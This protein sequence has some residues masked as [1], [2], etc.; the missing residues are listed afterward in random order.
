MFQAVLFSFVHGCFEGSDPDPCCA[1]VR[2]FIYFKYRVEFV[3]LLCDL[4]YLVGRDCIYAASKGVELNDLHI[5]SRSNEFCCSVQ[6]RMIDPLVQRTD[7]SRKIRQMKYGVFCENDHIEGCDDLVESVVD[8]RIEMVRTSCENDALF[9]VLLGP[10]QIHLTVSFDVSL[11]LSVFCPC[12]LHCLS[13][14]L[15]GHAVF[16]EEAVEFSHHELIVVVRQERMIELRSVLLEDLVHVSCDHFRIRGNDRTVV[17][18]WLVLI[19]YALIVDARIEDL[20]DSLVH[21]PLD[22]SVDHFGRI[23]CRIGRDRLH[24]ALIQRLAG[25]RRQDNSIPKVREECMPERIVLIH[26]QDS[27][28]TDDAARCHLFRQWI[29]IEESLE[30]ICIKVRD[31]IIFADG[32]ALAPLTSVSCEES[33]AVVEA[34]YGHHAVVFASVAANV[35][36]LDGEFVHLLR[37][38]DGGEFSLLMLRLSYQCCSVCSHKACDIRS[39]DLFSHDVLYG[40]ENSVVEE[41]SALYDDLLPCFVRVSEFDYFIESISDDGIAQ[42][43]TDIAD[44][45]AFLLGL[46]HLGVHEYCTSRSKINRRLCEESF[47][48]KILDVQVHGLRIRFDE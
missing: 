34:V 37:R 41:C 27:R 22:V 33:G 26:V 28:D 29:V 23:T 15:L 19:F 47:L 5:V 16:L 24:A 44:G 21:Q 32:L 17:V 18:V 39:Y 12:D 48:R 40:S 3:V 7:R 1:H 46:L 43:C 25:W 36:R 42:S 4:F 11:E 13:D 10:F 20:L 9:A 35:A 31:L 6:S 30:F 14:L 45:S 8:L 38:D 2:A